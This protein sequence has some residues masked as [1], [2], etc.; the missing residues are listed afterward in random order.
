MNYEDRWPLLSLRKSVS[1]AKIYINEFALAIIKHKAFEYTTIGVILAN[2]VTLGMED[3]LAVSTT[4]EQELVEYIFLALYSIEM[5]LKILGMGF[6]FNKGAYLRDP[7]NILD[8]I[9][10][11]SAYIG[12][13]QTVVD[14]VNND[15]VKPQVTAESGQDTGLS[16]ASLRAFRVLRPLRAVT[17][18]KGLQILVLSVIK[19]LP[20]LQEAIIVLMSFFVVFAIAGTQLLTGLLKNRC[21]KI[22]SGHKLDWEDGYYFCG[23]AQECPEGYFCGKQNENPSFGVTNFDNLMY[24]W[25]VVF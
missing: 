3:P 21:V 2:S 13:V 19:S 6:L 12:V 18:I 8:F 5:A 4:S 20:L 10:V 17:S 11:M 25:L 7:W 14:I 1:K 9:I 24:A 23:G 15:G 16:L 22:D